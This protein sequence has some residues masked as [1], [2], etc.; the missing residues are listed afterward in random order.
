MK[1]SY[2]SARRQSGR[3][4]VLD[5]RMRQLI[6]KR[7]KSPANKAEI[8]AIEWALP[9][10]EAHLK[11][12]FGYDLAIRTSWYKHEKLEIMANLWDR[13]GDICYLCS[14]TMRYREATIDH[15]VPLAKDGADNMTNYKLTHERC[16]LEKGNMLLEVYIDWRKQHYDNLA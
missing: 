9:I 8:S 16:N 7:G 4:A 11:N 2:D 5:R 10:L 6:K 12:T 13:D 1:G 3:V 14:E 15:V